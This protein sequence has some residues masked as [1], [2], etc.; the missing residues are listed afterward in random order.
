MA[1]PGDG[2]ASKEPVVGGFVGADQLPPSKVISYEDGGIALNDS[3]AGLLH[4][5]WKA[6][7]SDDGSRILISSPSHAESVFIAGTEISE[8]SLA[9]DSN[10]NPAV[11]YVEVGFA[12]LRWYDS[13]ID[14]YTTTNFPGASSP[15]LSTDD[16]RPGQTSQ[17]DIIFAYIRNGNLYYRQQRDRYGVEYLLATNV[18]GEFNQLGMNTAGRLQFEFDT[19]PIPV[20]AVYPNRTYHQYRKYRKLIQWLDIIPKISQEIYV[21]AE[22][23]RASYDIDLNSGKQLD[24]IGRIVVLPRFVSALVENDYTEFGNES[25]EFGANRSEFGAIYGSED[26]V[27]SDGLYKTLI[28]A[29]IHKNNREAT[30]DSI[31]EA[32]GIIAPENQCTVADNGDRSISLIFENQLTEIQRL[33]FTSFNILPIGHGIRIADIVDGEAA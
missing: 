13:L 9:F 19:F 8:V 1:L 22:K 17:R 12:R 10:M 27:F 33:I 26:T 20:L 3:S 28:K 6:C 29:K 23:I 14:D 4:Q 11:A 16:K 2:L 30:T 31:I 32:A 18:E 5:V 21:S 24:V 25:D 15:K 7:I